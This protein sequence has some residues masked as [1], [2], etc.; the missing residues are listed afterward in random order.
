MADIQLAQELLNIAQAST[1]RAARARQVAE[2]IRRHGEHN[3]V[4]VFLVEDDNLTL[5]AHTGAT[6]PMTTSLKLGEGLNGAAALTRESVVVND[7]SQDSRYRPTYGT[8]KAEVAIPVVDP[9]SDRVV[10]TLSVESD[11]VD[12]FGATEVVMLEVCAWA[13]APL[14]GG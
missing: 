10:A 5:L 4:G 8:T 13:I 11:R 7:V 9:L 14:W 6:T 1:P 2:T 3:W 12:A